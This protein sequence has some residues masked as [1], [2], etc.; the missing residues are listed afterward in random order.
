MIDTIGEIRALIA[1]QTQT[2]SKLANT[3][4]MLASNHGFIESFYRSLALLE[5]RVKV[6]EEQHKDRSFK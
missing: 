3:G 6:L 1:M 4:E 5:D 2:L